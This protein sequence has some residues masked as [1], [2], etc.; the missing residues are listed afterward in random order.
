MV[1]LALSLSRNY[2]PICR[3]LSF[4]LPTLVIPLP[5]C[6][7][8]I[9]LPWL[10]RGLEDLPGGFSYAEFSGVGSFPHPKHLAQCSQG[11]SMSQS[12]S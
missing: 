11:S 12:V 9:V 8:D 2:K 3:T 6:L 5:G 1:V 7:F 10:F 4:G